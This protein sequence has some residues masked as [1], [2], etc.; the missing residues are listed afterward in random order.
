MPPRTGADG[1]VR[2]SRSGAAA[3]RSGTGD[4]EERRGAVGD[5]SA[6]H[7]RCRT[8]TEVEAAETEI[9]E[10]RRTRGVGIELTGGRRRWRRGESGGAAARRADQSR[11]RQRCE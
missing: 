8:A 9:D 2:G 11:E 5:L 4:V 3:Q 1:A 7:D 10:L 6:G